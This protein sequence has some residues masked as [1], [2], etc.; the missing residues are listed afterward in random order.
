MSFSRAQLCLLRTHFSSP[1]ALLVELLA[2]KI[3]QLVLVEMSHTS[4]N[5][6]L[7]LLLLVLI[8]IKRDRECWQVL[9][10]SDLYLRKAV[11]TKSS[12]SWPPE[13]NSSTN[14]AFCSAH[15]SLVTS[16]CQHAEQ[17]IL[18]SP[19]AFPEPLCVK[20][21]SKLPSTAVGWCEMSTPTNN[22]HRD[23]PAFAGIQL[24]D[25]LLS[26]RTGMRL[27]VSCGESPQLFVAP[28]T[29]VNLFLLSGTH[30]EQPGRSEADET[31]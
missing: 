6:P 15:L 23:E 30:G 10:N 1:W 16:L 29:P 17:S 3:P 13:G 28:M 24:P 7:K 14:T 2:W 5:S 21:L 27:Q 12:S 8:W 26:G 4:N 22:R 11:P 18:H 25:S 31:R 19:L 20:C 9:G